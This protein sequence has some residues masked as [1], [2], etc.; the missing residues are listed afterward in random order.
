MTC[1]SEYRRSGFFT[2]RWEM[3]S[4]ASLVIQDGY[5]T[6]HA[7]MSS[8][9]RVMS[10]CW[11]GNIPVR[12]RY[13]MIPQDQASILTPEYPSSAPLMISGAQ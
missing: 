10:S 7:L 1:S 4:L 2:S 12:S 8:Y 3:R 11:N 13:R 9:N 6:L 5:G